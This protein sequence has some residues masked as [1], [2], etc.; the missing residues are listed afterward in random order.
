[1]QNVVKVSSICLV[2]AWRILLSIHVLLTFQVVP[3]TEPQVRMRGPGVFKYPQVTYHNKHST[4]R[5]V[6]AAF[7]N[8][9]LHRYT[10]NIYY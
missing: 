7:R 2:F 5:Q 8:F 6:S 9:P 1:M 10:Q 3:Y 4:V